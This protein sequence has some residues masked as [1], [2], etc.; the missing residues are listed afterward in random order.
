[1][2]KQKYYKTEKQS[3]TFYGGFYFAS[4]RSNF[5]RISR[6]LFSLR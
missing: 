2:Y 5:T 3:F 4:L 6:F 1:M